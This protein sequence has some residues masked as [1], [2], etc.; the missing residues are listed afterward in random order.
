VIVFPTSLVKQGSD[1]W[2]R[3]RLGRPTASEFG[4]I[5]TPAKGQKSASQRG[6]AARHV[7]ERVTGGPQDVKPYMSADMERGQMREH[8]ARM[9]FEAETGLC[10]S[11]VG[12]VTTDDGRFGASPDAL[13]YS[14]EGDNLIAGLEIKNYSAVD[15][16]AWQEEGTLPNDF[17]CQVHGS[18]VVTGLKQWWWMNNCPPYDP[19][20]LLVLWDDFTT[21]L[22]AALEEFDRDVFKPLLAKVC[23]N[24]AIRRQVEEFDREYEAMLA[25]A[26]GDRR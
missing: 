18:M 19:I 17:K 12:F 1:E 21:K 24:G 3:L 10:T 13:V 2:T 4:S 26:K 23:E 11:K 25:K 9:R 5:L 14:A 8:E 22:A 16:F 7:D 6:F 15:H 20:I